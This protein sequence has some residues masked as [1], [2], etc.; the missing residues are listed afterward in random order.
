[1][2]NRK[3]LVSPWIVTGVEVLRDCIIE[4][5]SEWS[6]KGPLLIVM[7]GASLFLSG[8]VLAGASSHRGARGVA[9][10]KGSME[11]K[12]SFVEGQLQC[13]G[14]AQVVLERVDFLGVVGMS[15]IA[16]GAGTQV[17]AS[18]CNFSGAVMTSCVA[19]NDARLILQRTTLRDSLCGVYAC[20]GAQVECVDFRCSGAATGIL[21]YDR[22]VA[23]LREA[24]FRDGTDAVVACKHSTLT[25][26][27]LHINNMERNGCVVAKSRAEVK[28]GQIRN[29][30]GRGI[31]CARASSPVH[32]ES[33]QITDNYVGIWSCW[34]QLE[35]QHVQFQR[36]SSDLV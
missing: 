33:L 26:E 22:A 4:A 8:C 23:S 34:T 24:S 11:C 15:L 19:L 10:I 20:C 32:L 28:G 16:S 1:M 35:M 30:S 12:D 36:N 18:E 14:G 29:C 17:R 31:V 3:G 13:S 7:P 5:S 25:C 27:L 9:L 21:V 6:G 2:K